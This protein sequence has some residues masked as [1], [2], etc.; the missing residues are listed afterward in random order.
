MATVVKLHGILGSNSSTPTSMAILD[1]WVQKPG[2]DALEG[3][4]LVSNQNA[5]GTSDVM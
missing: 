4:A 5:G 3:T 1:E 2:V